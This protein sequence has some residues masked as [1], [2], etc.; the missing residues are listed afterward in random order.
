MNGHLEVNKPIFIEQQGFVTSKACVTNLLESQDLTT[1]ALH[2][3]K[4]LDVL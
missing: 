4:E 1:I 3:H 2:V